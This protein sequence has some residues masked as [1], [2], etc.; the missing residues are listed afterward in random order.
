MVHDGSCDT[1][2]KYGTWNTAA[3]ASRNGIMPVRNFQKTG[4]DKIELVDGDALLRTIYAGKRTCPGCPIGCRRVVKG[5]D[6]YPVSEEYGGPQ[7]ETVTALGPLLDNSDPFL[8]AKAGERCN[9]LGLD[10]IST[11]VAIAFAME[12]YER[13]ALTERD[14]GYPLPW[15]DEE[16]ILRLIEEIGRRQGFGAVLAEGV[17]RA[18]AHVAE[19]LEC[20]GGNGFIEECILPRL[21]REAP[22]N[23]IW[24]GS[25]NVIALDLL[26]T[27]AKDPES[28]DRVLAEIRLAGDRRVDVFLEN[29]RR[30]MAETG[31]RRFAERLALAL[32][33]SLLIRFSPP[34]VADAFCASR[35]AG[36]SGRTFGTLPPESD[37]DRILTAAT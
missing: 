24:E 28:L 5:N 1:L 33:A 34:A 17:K 35:L 30:D 22:L 9:L 11:G 27:V 37:C 18:A 2:A 10:T 29:L 12:C 21:Y 32:E 20:L 19:A 14:L 25:G 36:A 23:S 31:A 16:G 8:I 15:G 13:G 3:P 7:Y 6:R 4:Y 26:R